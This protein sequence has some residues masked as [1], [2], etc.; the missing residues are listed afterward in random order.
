MAI[1]GSLQ[2]ALGLRSAQYREGLDRARAQ[3]R[4][5]GRDVN[6]QTDQIRDNFRQL[7][8]VIAGVVGGLGVAELGRTALELDGFAAAAGVTSQRF[9]Q[10][11]TVFSQFNI[12]ADDVRDFFTETARGIS[13]LGEGDTAGAAGAIRDLG[14]SFNQ[15]RGLSPEDQFF[16]LFEA[17]QNVQQEFDRVRIAGLLFGEDVSSRLAPALRLTRDELEAIAGEQAV[18]DAADIAV[19][20]EATLSFVNLRNSLISLASGFRPFV[21]ILTPVLN[22][23]ADLVSSSDLVAIAIGNLA[24]VAIGGVL[25]GAI[26]RAISSISRF[27]QAAAIG[28]AGFNDYAGAVTDGALGTLRLTGRIDRLSVRLGTAANR[29]VR[30]GAGF[31]TLASAQAAASVALRGLGAAIRFALGPIGLVLIGIEGLIFI[32][33]RWG[34][35]IINFVANIWQRF[36]DTIMRGFNVLA[37]FIGLEPWIAVEDLGDAATDAMEPLNNLANSLSDINNSLEGQALSEYRNE[38]QTIL[39]E[40]NPASRAARVLASQ[41]DTLNQAFARGDITLD[42]YG[43]TVGILRENYQEFLASLSDMPDGIEALDDSFRSVGESIQTNLRDTLVEAFRTGELS[44]RSFLDSVTTQILTVFSSRITN[45]IIGSI[46]GG[47]GAGGS[48]FGNLGTILG[49]QNGGVVPRTPGSRAGVDS[50]PALLTPGETVTPAGQ[51]PGGL[52]V[53]FNVTGDVTE[54]TLRVIETQSLR[55]ATIVEQQLEDRG[56]L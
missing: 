39:D 26:A 51:V 12:Q 49:F 11:A 48:L 50:V 40:V 37:D 23:F 3:T 35:E 53:N 17:L 8:G 13:E 16:T 38:L 45:S 31:L 19:F 32:F 2:V 28:S 54:Q 6:R 5:F 22:R 7:T 20:R 25:L 27:R 47:G 21:D 55:V 46:F 14:L 34:D 24:L 15:L 33:N 42:Q 52:T 36:L 56:R 4:R 1:I 9:Q 41:I 30:A 43:M 18:F 44:A 10:L 29:A